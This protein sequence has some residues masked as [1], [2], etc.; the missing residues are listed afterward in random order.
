MKLQDGESITYESR[1]ESTVLVMWLFEK[2]LA[3]AFVGFVVGMPA[4]IA[5]AVVKGAD[6]SFG[7]AFGAGGVVAAAFFVLATAYCC[8]LVKTYAYYVTN[9]RCVFRGGILRRVEHSVPFHKVTD[10]EISQNILERA[11]GISKLKIFTPGTGSSQGKAEI[12]FVGLK[13]PDTP[14]SAIQNALAKLKDRDE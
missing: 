8:A 10:V 14:A 6:D 7:A 3:A 13:D 5:L 2:C 12:R 1:P 4:G 9:R 11:L